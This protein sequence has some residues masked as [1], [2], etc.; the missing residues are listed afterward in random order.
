MENMH[1]E[2]KSN[3]RPAGLQLQAQ[4]LRLAVGV[5]IVKDKKPRRRKGVVTPDERWGDI[6]SVRI[7]GDPMSQTNFGELDQLDCSCR[8]SSYVSV[9]G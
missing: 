3:Q 5:D 1:R 6:S 7:D 9:W 2:Q 8:L 4:Q